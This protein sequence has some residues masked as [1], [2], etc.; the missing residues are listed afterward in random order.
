[1]G[2]LGK[3]CK[4][5]KINK[6]IAL[7]NRFVCLEIDTSVTESLKSMPSLLKMERFSIKHW[8]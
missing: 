5:L 2:L 3:K 7:K 6:I 8:A 1:M 4:S